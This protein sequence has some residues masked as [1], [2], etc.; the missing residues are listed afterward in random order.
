MVTLADALSYLAL[1]CSTIPMKMATKRPAVRWKRF[2]TLRPDDKQLRKWFDHGHDYGLAVIFGDVSNGLASRD[3]DDLETYQ[4]WSVEHPDLAKMLPTA[5]TRRGRHVYCRFAADDV[6]AFRRLIGKPDGIGAIH[7]DG[8]ELRIGVG[9]YSVIPPSRHPSGF[10][11]RWLVSP[12]DRP[13]PLLTVSDSGFFGHATERTEMA[14]KTESTEKTEA[15]R[16]GEEAAPAPPHGFCLLCCA[17]APHGI[18]TDIEPTEATNAVDLAIRSTLPTCP[19]ERNKLVFGLARALKAI[20]GLI[21]ADLDRLQPLVRQWHNLAKPNIGTPAFEETWL[22][23]IHAWPRVK[24][25]GKEP[26]AMILATAIALEP[27]EAVRHYESEP[28]KLLASLCRELQRATGDA[29][30]FLSVRTVGKYFN[31]DP[32]T[33]S[34]WLTLLRV[35]R[36][37]HEVEKGTQKTGRASRFRFLG[38]LQPPNSKPLETNHA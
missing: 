1:G 33:A 27:P 19:G 34:R 6:A 31:V 7:C 18:E 22:D 10:V 2:Q 20:P 11:Y 28:L 12:F 13:I 21:D 15:I 8:G 17:S 29:P 35:D 16:V 32:G 26:M 5:E 9:C 25:P 36:V 24:F 4:R 38:S 14:E 30:F 3:F 23:F 37:I